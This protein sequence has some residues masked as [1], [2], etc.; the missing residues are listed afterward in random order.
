V[1]RAPGGSGGGCSMMVDVTRGVSGPLAGSVWPAGTAT[2]DAVKPHHVPLRKPDRKVAEARR[3]GAGPT[4]KVNPIRMAGPA[5]TLPPV[6]SNTLQG[7]G[8]CGRVSWIHPCCFAGLRMNARGKCWCQ[9]V[10]P[11]D[12]QPG[13]TQH[14]CHCICNCC[15]AAPNRP[16]PSHMTP[17]GGGEGG[18][19]EGGGGEGGGGEGGGG[20]GGGGDSGLQRMASKGVGAPPCGCA[21]IGGPLARLPCRQ[22]TRASPIPPPHL[23]L[24]ISTTATAAGVL[25][26]SK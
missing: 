2:S 1:S 21:S 25:V 7:R 6:L 20:E 18:G 16:K 3:A 11:P 26:A 19:G 23:S 15:M 5:P 22:P 9:H 14:K 12:M 17:A 4:R 13:W 8:V 24:P 10:D